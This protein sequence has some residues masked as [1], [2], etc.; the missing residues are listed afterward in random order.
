MGECIRQCQRG[1]INH[2]TRAPCSSMSVLK[3]NSA[4]K[5]AFR[6]GSSQAFISPDRPV[7]ERTGV[8]VD[9]SRRVFFLDASFDSTFSRKSVCRGFFSQH[10]N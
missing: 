3:G 9:E 10:G 6:I 2:Q 5:F 8:S 4:M 1:A 7:F